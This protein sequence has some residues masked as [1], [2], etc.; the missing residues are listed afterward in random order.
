L[1]QNMRRVLAWALGVSVVLVV[2]P[3][4]AQSS[5][6]QDSVVGSGSAGAGLFLNIAIDARSDP[7]GGN[8][9]GNVSFTLVL[10][11]PPP[12]GV[13]IGG[14]VTCL[15]VS[16]NRAVIGFVD[17]TTGFPAITVEVV[18]NGP[19]GSPPDTFGAAPF[20]TDCLSDPDIDPFPLDSGDI[21]VHDATTPSTKEDCKN[22]GWRN[23][24][25]DQ[26]EPFGNQGLCEAFVLRSIHAV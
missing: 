10:P 6:A 17:T 1:E 26:G 8:P 18:D 13:P 4:F 11:V 22:G 15:G 25:D 9:S 12:G 7:L 14:P 19:T 24:T 16:G 5:V 3:G 20:P 2:S 21:V 23:L